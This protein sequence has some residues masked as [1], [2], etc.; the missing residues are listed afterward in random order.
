MTRA[1]IL[2][3]ALALSASAATAQ[4][5]YVTPGYGHPAP[6]YVA[7]GPGYA[8]PNYSF[9]QSAPDSTPMQCQLIR[10]AVAQYGFAAARRHALETYGPEAVKTGDKC[11]TKQ[12]VRGTSSYRPTALGAERSARVK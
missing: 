10:L 7:P 2:G 4:E 11:F 6:T 1:L 9:A 8:A 5:V 3:T 12:A